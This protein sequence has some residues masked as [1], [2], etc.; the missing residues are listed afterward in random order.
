MFPELESTDADMICASYKQ[1]MIISSKG[2]FKKWGRFLS[3]E[4]KKKKTGKE[5]ADEN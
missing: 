5:G 2:Q 1:G 3:G 4:K